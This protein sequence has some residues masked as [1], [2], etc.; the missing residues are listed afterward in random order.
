MNNLEHKVQSCFYP[1]RSN[2]LALIVNSSVSS[3]P[4]PL[5]KNTN[6]AFVILGDP[7]LVVDSRSRISYPGKKLVGLHNY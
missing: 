2:L 5:N 3:S 7:V 1:V 6:D 4:R